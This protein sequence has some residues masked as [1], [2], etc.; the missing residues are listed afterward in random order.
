MD[1]GGVWVGQVAFIIFSGALTLGGKE[2]WDIVQEKEAKAGK[3]KRESLYSFY[4]NGIAKKSEEGKGILVAVKTLVGQGGGGIGLTGLSKSLTEYVLDAVAEQFYYEN[5]RSLPL[6]PTEILAE[7]FLREDFERYRRDLA[8]FLKDP[9]YF[10]E[11][12]Q[13]ELE[14][15]LNN[16]QNNPNPGVQRDC[17][18]R[19]W[20]FYERY[21]K[22]RPRIP[23]ES[24]D[25]LKHMVERLL[26]EGYAGLLLILDEVSLFMQGRQP[27]DRV[28]DEKALVVLSNRLAKVE[29]LPVWMVCAA[30][31]A[32]ETKSV[33]IKNI[34]ADE[35]LKLV[36]LL[37]KADYYYDIALNRVREITD[38]AAIDQYYEDYKRSFSW[39]Q[40][41]G[42]DQFARFF[43][44]YPPAIDVVRAVSYNLTTVRSALYFMLETIKSMRK[45]QSDELITLWSLFDDV[46]SYE[47]DPSGT[48]R[49]IASIKTKFPEE[50]QAFEEAKRQI[51]N[52]LGGPLKVYR[53]RCEKIVKTLFLYHIA[54]LS[55]NGLTHEELMNSVMEWKDHDKDRQADLQDNFDHYESLAGKLDTELVQVEKVGNHYRFNPT[56]SGTDP[57]ELFLKARAEAENNA[58]LRRDAWH[59]LLALDGWYVNT[60]LMSLDLAHNTQSIFR[61]IAPESQTDLTIRWHGREISGRIYMRDLLDIARR[62]AQLPSINSPDTGLDFH[63]YASSTAANSELDT[64]VNLE[65]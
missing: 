44:F 32:I 43:P 15:F 60:S 59:Q 36:P 65:K 12:K 9:A 41:F 51:D 34:I 50:W 54:N 64:L 16:L 42:K 20:D 19:L 52:S 2:E 53:S 39:P 17:G 23:M 24:E 3:G 45:R 21:L 26:E 6:Y 4:E 10:D 27:A 14:E 22:T 40:A 58:A 35:R 7:R 62:S 25:V 29:N 63:V 55:P 31:Q 47:E 38:A 61:S 46:V 5:D 28:E 57:H 18:Q 30:Q 37:N 11:E 1:P 56:G 49:G 33:G 13:W 8:K 48:S